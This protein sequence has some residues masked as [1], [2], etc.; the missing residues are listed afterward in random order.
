MIKFDVFD[1]IQ[2]GFKIFIG[3]SR[4]S[5]DK[6]CPQNG[7]GNI[8]ADFIEKPVEIVPGIPAAHVF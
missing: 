5:Q 6:R 1:E 4:K 7:I 2:Q 3:F 8:C